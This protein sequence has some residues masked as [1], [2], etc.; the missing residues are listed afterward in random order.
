[1]NNIKAPCADCFEVCSLPALKSIPL[2]CNHHRC[3]CP[4][5]VHLPKAE[6][7]NPPF[8]ALLCHTAFCLSK[9]DGSGHFILTEL[10]GFCPSV[11][12]SFH[13]VQF[14]EVSSRLYCVPN[15]LLKALPLK[16]LVIFHRAHTPY[17]IYENKLNYLYSSK[18]SHTVIPTLLIIIHRASL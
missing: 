16:G 4:D 8:S 13:W 15:A 3:M 9:S 10:C 2:W 7:L 18:P 12:G 14:P 11:P 5:R 1:M 6:T 17:F